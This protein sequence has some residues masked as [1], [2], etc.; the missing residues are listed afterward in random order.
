MSKE[1]TLCQAMEE[2]RRR[3]ECGD[4]REGEW[5]CEGELNGDK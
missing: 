2:S 1:S 5:V 3:W 4:G